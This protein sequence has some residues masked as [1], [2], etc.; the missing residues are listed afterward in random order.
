MHGD[1]GYCISVF[2]ELDWNLGRLSKMEY[3]EIGKRL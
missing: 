3:G 2:L 1:L